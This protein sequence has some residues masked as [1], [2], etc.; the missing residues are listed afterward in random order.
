MN[1]KESLKKYH[2]TIPCRMCEYDEKEKKEMP[3]LMCVVRPDFSN[4]ILKN[5]Y[6]KF[7]PKKGGEQNAR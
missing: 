1:G 6:R 7:T 5:E 2:C 3:C 4:D